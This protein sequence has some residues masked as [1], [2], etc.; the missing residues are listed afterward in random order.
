MDALVIGVGLWVIMFGLGCATGFAWARGNQYRRF[1]KEYRSLA[2]EWNDL[3]AE[4][5]DLTA[6]YK[7]M[8]EMWE[9][10]SDY[11]RPVTWENLH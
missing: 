8:R 9:R 4:W 2:K 10:Q 6:E 5:N 11:E 7:K 3:T 1:S